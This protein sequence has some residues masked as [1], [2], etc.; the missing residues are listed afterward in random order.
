M[1]IKFDFFFIH[2]PLFNIVTHEEYNKVCNIMDLHKTC[3][4]NI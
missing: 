4:N 3:F 2:S 1:Q